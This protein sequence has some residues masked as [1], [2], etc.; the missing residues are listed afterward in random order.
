MVPDLP[1]TSVV[2]DPQTTPASIIVASD[3]GVLRTSDNGATWQRL[4]I[5]LPNVNVTS[6]NIDYTVTP[7]LLRA[8][9]YGRSA[10]EL[11]TATGPLLGVNCEL[12]FG[13]VDRSRRRRGS[14]RSST[15][16][17]R[18]CTCNSVHPLGREHGL[19]DPVRAAAT[20][21]TIQPGEHVDWTIAFKPTAVGDL[22]GDVPD[23]E[24]RPV[25]ADEDAQR[26]R[27]GVSGQIGVSGDLNFG[28]VPRGQ[29]ASR[30]L[31]VQNIGAGT[32]K[33]TSVSLLAAIRGS[34]SSAAGLRPPTVNIA[35]GSQVTYTV[36][37]APPANATGRGNPQTRTFRILSNAPSSPTEVTRRAE[38]ACRRSLSAATAS[39]TAASPSTTGRRRTTRR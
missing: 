21:V 26:E 16:A 5:G 36:Q 7:S 27:H 38:S 35:P 22:N 6:L 4:G 2:I 17:R 1:L 11:T 31:I 10:F 24:R 39:R 12:G 9:T 30:N 14:A 3:L 23:L 33:L 8:A 37:F 15:S 29:T 13:V 34:R 18:T 32:L 28:T 25:R 19:L 20:P